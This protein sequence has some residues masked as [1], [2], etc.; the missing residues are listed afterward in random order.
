MAFLVS[1]RRCKSYR[2][3]ASRRDVSA[4][5][6]HPVGGGTDP[7]RPSDLPILTAVI[8]NRLGGVHLDDTRK[9][10]ADGRVFKLLDDA[11]EYSPQVLRFD[12]VY[13]ELRAIGQGIDQLAGR[14]AL[15]E[16]DSVTTTCRSS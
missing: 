8:A 4:C 11:R 1:V 5:R 7:E 3:L 15:G 14:R 16:T 10:D 12:L 13:F 9:D 2:F 6:L